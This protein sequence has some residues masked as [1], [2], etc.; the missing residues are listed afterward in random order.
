MKGRAAA[1][2]LVFL[3]RDGTI[4]VDKG[5]VHRVEDF[6]FLPGAVEALKRLRHA[7]IDI[8]VVTNQSGIARGFYTEADLAAVN[9]HMTAELARHGVTLAG[10]HYCPHHPDAS[11]P[12]YRLACDCRK[13]KPGLLLAAMRE[14]GIAAR[15]A[16]M[17]GDKSSDIDA[18]I[19]AGLTGTYL[20]QT[21]RAAGDGHGGLAR[22]VV[23][24]LRSAVDH[25]IYLASTSTRP[26]S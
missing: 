14:R 6:E 24:D 8:I 4:N 25:I 16:V 15:E 22:Y 5:Y 11:V 3:D 10:I 7:G 23:P 17:I 19:A 20:V 1:I 13:P 26:P 12:R 18:G 2:R 21:G 9:A